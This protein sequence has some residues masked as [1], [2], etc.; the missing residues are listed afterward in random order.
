MNDPKRLSEETSQAPFEA[1][2]LRSARK[3]GLSESD[4]GA[5]WSSLASELALASLPAA[6]D[7]AKPPGVG[8][9]A[10]N[11]GATKAGTS[12]A[13]AL[14]FGKSLAITA[15]ALTLGVGG[16]VWLRPAE[17]PRKEPAP[18]VM[19]QT[20]MPLPTASPSSENGEPRLT[21]ESSPT[22]DRAP[23]SPEAAPSATGS[24]RHAAAASARVG[25]AG[26]PTPAS[27]LRE[28]SLG[29]VAARQSLRSGDFGLALTRLEEVRARFPHGA[30]A[31]EREALT[32]ETLGRSGA[33]AAAQK[34]ARAFL[35]AYPKSPYAADVERYAKP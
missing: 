31:Q 7:A 25:S 10:T 2:I 30:L 17:A 22:L 26:A 16:Y 4:K 13:S 24:A 14:G 18:P 12:A 27:L 8:S 28:E 5:I 3:V 11:A 33:R 32:I 34:R 20:S 19:A 9:G 29:I 35:Q 6:A 23:L 15:V 1:D 21:P